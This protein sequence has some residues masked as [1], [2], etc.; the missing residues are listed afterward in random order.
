MFKAKVKRDQFKDKNP[1]LKSSLCAIPVY[2][3][4]IVMFK[5]RKN[6]II[7]IYPTT[8]SFAN[9]LYTPLINNDFL[10]KK[11]TKAKLVVSVGEVIYNNQVIVVFVSR[12]LGFWK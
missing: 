12:V 9:T 8:H 7:S 1:I 5:W 3:D 10:A 4:A 11:Y 6:T 2:L